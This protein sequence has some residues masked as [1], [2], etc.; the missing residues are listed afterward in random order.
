MELNKILDFETR[1]L[2]I[3]SRTRLM[4]EGEKSSKYFC[5]L[6]KKIVRRSVFIKLKMKMQR[7]FF[8]QT[9]I[10][11]EIHHY[12]QKRYSKNVFFLRGMK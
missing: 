2:M 12:F 6:K 8:Y 3:R 4:E 9:D 11:K 10:V 7:M 5:N 1:G